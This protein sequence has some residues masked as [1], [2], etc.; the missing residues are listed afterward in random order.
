[1]ALL[2]FPSLPNHPCTL[3]CHAPSTC[4]ETDPCRTPI[5][6]TCPCGRVKQ[7]VNCGR[8]ALN[9]TRSTQ[10]APKC[11]NDC[12]IAKRNARLAEALGI[13]TEAREKAGNVAYSDELSNFARA[14]SKFIPLVEKA[15]AE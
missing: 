14:N 1:M 10:S 9:P 13:N 4:P 6:L 8:T 7:I 15:F 12:L 2:I 11:T 5:T 3:P